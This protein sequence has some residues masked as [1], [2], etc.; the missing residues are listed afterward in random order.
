MERERKEA[1]FWFRRL[2]FCRAAYT[3]IF[4][5]F[6]YCRFFNR[7]IHSLVISSSSSSSSSC[8]RFSFRLFINYYFLLLPSL[9]SSLSISLSLWNTSLCI[10]LFHGILER[11]CVIS[12]VMKYSSCANQQQAL[13]IHYIHIIYL[14]VMIALTHKCLTHCDM[15]TIVHVSSLSPVLF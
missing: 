5:L 1:K 6:N 11:F 9:L 10:S 3:N 12:S 4:E 13:R 15:Y 7:F 14:L 8:N 2:I